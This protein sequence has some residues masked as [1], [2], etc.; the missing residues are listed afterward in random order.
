MLSHERFS[1][2]NAAG[3]IGRAYV[4]RHGRC[5]PSNSQPPSRLLGQVRARIR[6]KHQSIRTEQACT[7]WIKRFIS[8]HRKQHPAMLGASEVGVFLTH[9]AVER[10]IAAATQNQAGG[11][12]L[13]LYKDVLGIVALTP[14]R[15]ACTGIGATA[16]GA[17]G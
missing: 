4:L 2:I 8:L 5:L 14:W 9:L 15:R 10:N 16:G 7:D 1:G 13:F 3:S 6:F 11:A 17:H 12:L